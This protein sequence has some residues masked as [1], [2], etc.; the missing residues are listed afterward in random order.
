MDALALDPQV[1]EC[2]TQALELAAP[3]PP[4][5]AILSRSDRWKPPVREGGGLADDVAKR[6]IEAE[7]DGSA[8]G[9]TWASYDR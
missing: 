4:D 6:L 3:P 9:L 5:H 7:R 2:S 1:F 8:E